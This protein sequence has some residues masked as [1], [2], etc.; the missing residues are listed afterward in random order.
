VIAKPDEFITSLIMILSG[1]WPTERT[2]R[3]G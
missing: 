3:A 1:Q 2:Y